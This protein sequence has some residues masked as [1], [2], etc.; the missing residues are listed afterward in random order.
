MSQ[1]TITINSREYPIACEDG[2]ELR[3][4]QLADILDEKAK[5]IAGDSSQ[6]NESLLMTMVGLLLADE[7]SEAKKNVDN[8]GNLNERKVNPEDMQKLDTQIAEALQN[9][10]NEIKTLVKTINSL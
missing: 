7:L 3:I 1:I 5:L 8:P 10:D 9:V 2:Q 4:M 6:I